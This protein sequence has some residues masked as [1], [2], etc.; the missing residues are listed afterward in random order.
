MHFIYHKPEVQGGDKIKLGVSLIHGDC[1]VQIVRDKSL[2]HTGKLKT[3]GAAA[4]SLQC[5]FWSLYVLSAS[6]YPVVPGVCACW[7]S[8]VCGT[9]HR[10]QGLLRICCS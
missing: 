6:K 3:P 1:S 4:L 9:S 7:A 5:T 2:F 8:A 10:H